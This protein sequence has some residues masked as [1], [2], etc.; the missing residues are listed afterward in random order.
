ML[1]KI[2]SVAMTVFMMIQG[3]SAPVFAASGADK[4]RNVTVE[5]IEQLLSSQEKELN[6]KIS[7]YGAAGAAGTALVGGGIYVYYTQKQIALL[8][9]RN[10]VLSHKVSRIESMIN[11]AV[12]DNVAINRKVAKNTKLVQTNKAYID[13]LVKYVQDII[14]ALNSHSEAIN[15]LAEEAAEEATAAAPRR[16]I[17]FN[18]SMS[19]RAA[20][21]A[22]EA[23]TK[24]LKSL[25]NISKKAGIVGLVIAGLVTT[26]YIYNS[27]DKANSTA[28][29]SKRIAYKRYLDNAYK[30]DEGFFV[31]D[32]LALSQEDRHMAASILH[33]SIG[34]NADYYSRFVKQQQAAREAAYE[35]NALNE[36]KD[37]SNNVQSENEKSKA[38]LSFVL[39]DSF[40]KDYINGFAI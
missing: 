31:F 17:G 20:K 6:K 30:N 11:A 25:K 2:I 32:V 24:S 7:L 29:S 33:E 16:P 19:Q 13:Q 21:E 39:D 8:K 35:A 9:K 40:V 36:I 15:S 26:A 22:E 28:I 12:K 38:L 4:Q 18:A 1:R 5:D 14:G 23:A 34:S 10:L 3:I 27:Y 37:F